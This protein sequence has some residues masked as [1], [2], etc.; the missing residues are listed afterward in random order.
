MET[1]A[2]GRTSVSE[3]L[4][5]ECFICVVFPWIDHVLLFLSASAVKLTIDADQNRRGARVRFIDNKQSTFTGLLSFSASACQEL[6][7]SVNVRVYDHAV[8]T[9]LHTDIKSLSI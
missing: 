3:G 6:E 7:L 1:A 9:L 2:S 5:Q 8:H 4:I